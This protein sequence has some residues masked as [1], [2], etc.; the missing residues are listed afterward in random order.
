MPSGATISMTGTKIYSKPQQKR[1]RLHIEEGILEPRIPL[2]PV[3]RRELAGDG[4]TT[5]P[6]AADVLF[7]LELLCAAPSMVVH[8]ESLYLYFKRDG[9]ITQ[10]PD[11]AQTAERGYAA[12]LH[13]LDSGALRLSNQVRAAAHA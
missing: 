2:F 5:V 9:S 10:A 8:P 4:W 12:I 3:F 11:T 13:L 1:R 7:N 6:F